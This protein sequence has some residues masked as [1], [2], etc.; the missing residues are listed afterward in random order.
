MIVKNK[1]NKMYKTCSLIFQI[2]EINS[3]LPT[4]F[5]AVSDDC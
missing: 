3:L 4:I 5:T 1:I 2:P